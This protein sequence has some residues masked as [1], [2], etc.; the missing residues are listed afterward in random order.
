MEPNLLEYHIDSIKS[1]LQG[2]LDRQ[3]QKRAV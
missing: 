2:I 3:T 1:I